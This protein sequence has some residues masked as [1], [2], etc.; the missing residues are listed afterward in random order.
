M[1]TGLKVEGVTLFAIG[2]ILREAFAEMGA[3]IKISNS[4]NSEGRGKRL[5]S[6]WL[7]ALRTGI[8]TPGIDPTS[9]RMQHNPFTFV[10]LLQKRSVCSF[11]ACKR[12]AKVGQFQNNFYFDAIL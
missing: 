11:R 7:G 12:I 6:N 4:L 1:R 2:N 9:D 5:Y 3:A 10:I 8:W